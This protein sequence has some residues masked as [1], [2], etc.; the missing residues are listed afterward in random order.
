MPKS[1]PDPAKGEAPVIGPTEASKSN[2]T[3]Y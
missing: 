2:P 1:K 3:Y